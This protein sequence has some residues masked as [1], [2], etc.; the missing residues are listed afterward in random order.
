[1]IWR[2][3]YNLWHL[4]LLVVNCLLLLAIA[5]IWWGENGAPV[6]SRPGKGPELP[7]APLLRDQQPISAFQVVAAKDLFS[8]DRNAPAVEQAAKVETTLEGRTLLGTMIIGTERVALISS[9][10][11]AAARGRQEP[12]IDVVHQGEEWEGFKILGISSESVVLEGK[13][14]K[15]ILNFPE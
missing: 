7:K 1:M 11:G 5:H 3:G 14:G 13:D 10:P 4:I 9:K 12:Q 8:Q 15:K 2:R 6:A